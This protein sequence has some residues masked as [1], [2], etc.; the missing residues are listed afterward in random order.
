MITGVWVGYDKPRP[1]GKGFTGGAVAAPIWE[2]F[3]RP[4]LASEPAVD[5]P[6]PDSVVAAAIDQE[7]GYLA[8]PDCPVQ[9]DEFYLVG[10]EPTE[11]CPEH[12]GLPAEPPPADTPPLD[13]GESSPA[14]LPFPTE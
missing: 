12:G 1:G 14:A 5:F 11:Y 6:Q 13:A 3:M 4:A 10:S 9:R 2:R 8:T 7:T